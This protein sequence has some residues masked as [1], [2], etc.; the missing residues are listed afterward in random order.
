MSRCELK[1]LAC[2]LSGMAYCGHCGKAL[3][4]RYAKSGQYSYYV[5]GTLD[6]KG[7]GSCQARYLKTEWFEALVIEMIKRRILTRDTLT[8]LVHL[9]NEEMDTTMKS[10]QDELDL[11][12]QATN[13]VN[14]R[15]ER[16]YDT[17][18]TG[19]I[20]LDELVPR[21]HGMRSRQEQLQLRRIE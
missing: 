7:G 4:G 19:M 18:E 3:V 9:V 13:D 21:I 2:P 5:C 15:L 8:N 16:L 14:H 10:H 12:S 6:K 11:M 17:I 1:T 20:K